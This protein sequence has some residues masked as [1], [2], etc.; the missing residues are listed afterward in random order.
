[1]LVSED[2]QAVLNARVG[3][4]SP[5]LPVAV[6]VV[7]PTASARSLSPAIEFTLHENLAAVAPTWRAFEAVADCT[8]FQTFAWH[9]AW[10]R[11]VG[12]RNQVRPVIVEGREG[13]R[14]LFIMP[15]AMEQGMLVRR[16]IWHASD[17]CDYNAPLLARDFSERVPVS[18]FAALWEEIGARISSCPRLRHDVIILERMPE[19]VGGQ[20]NPF[21][22]LP[23]TPHASGAYLMGIAGDWETFYRAKRS[24]AT[25]R[26]DR[27]KLRRLGEAG[28]VSLV[29]AFDRE[30]VEATLAT[31][32]AQKAVSFA[33]RGVSNFLAR[34]GYRDF[35]VDIA[36]NPATGALVHVSKL[37][38][39]NGVAAAN[40]GLVFGGR[41]YHVVA[42]YDAG[43]LA[44]FG[45]GTAHLH[46]LIAY[47][48]QRGCSEFDFTVGDEPYKR[49]WCDS[50]TKLFDLRL[51]RNLRG[52]TVA[53]AAR[54]ASRLKRG[55]KQS[56]MLWRAFTAA[57]LVTARVKRNPQPAG[58][59]SAD[60]AAG[61]GEGR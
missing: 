18:R 23:V 48:L 53:A 35:Y 38:A 3:L 7:R 25:R 34:P 43:E 28:P 60:R 55:V 29:T 41:Y 50:E 59:R 30:A 45:P 4:A 51:A 11:H 40:L 52:W 8:A 5:S 9:D 15:L 20:T 56:P 22:H 39:G 2:T 33:R 44:R 13:G 1:M 58:C 31:L 19:V 36:S 42:S 61:G 26:H 27:A 6:S 49:D 32:F 24:S 47:A 57:R 17:L 21:A 46:E 12:E 14:L 37:Q 10:Q 16:L 54:A